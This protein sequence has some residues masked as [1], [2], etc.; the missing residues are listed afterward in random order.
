M[1]LSSKIL[2]FNRQHTNDAVITTRDC[3]S[4]GT[5]PAAASAVP[6]VV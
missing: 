5:T 2:H 3:M 6:G 4:S 1:A